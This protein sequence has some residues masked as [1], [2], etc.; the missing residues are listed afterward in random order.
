MKSRQRFIT[1]ANWP[2]LD[3][4]PRFKQPRKGNGGPPSRQPAPW[5][6]AEERIAHV[7]MAK[8]HAQGSEGHQDRQTAGQPV[9]FKTTMA[10]S[11]QPT[12]GTR[13]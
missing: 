2:S 1:R 12:E 13:Q 10:A 6:R 8:Q 5:P 7:D 3:A 4:N 11:G 9:A